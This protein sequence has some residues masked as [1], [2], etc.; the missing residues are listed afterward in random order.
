MRYHCIYTTGAQTRSTVSAK[1]W[2]EREASGTLIHCLWEWK[3]VQPLGKMILKTKYTLTTWSSNHTSW[4]LH[5]EFEN[6]DHTKTCT[7]K[8]IVLLLIA[9]N[10]EETNM[11]FRVWMDKMWYIQTM[12]YHSVLKR[13]VLLSHEEK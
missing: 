7:Q 3:M 6:Y 8:I 4:Y 13:R 11:S 9:K 5:E 1:C 12:E 10:L 2:Q